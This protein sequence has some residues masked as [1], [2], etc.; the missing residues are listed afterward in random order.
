MVMAY[1][2]QN[3]VLRESCYDIWPTVLPCHP[4]RGY[5]SRQRWCYTTLGN[6][7]CQSWCCTTPVVPEQ[8]ELVFHHPGG[9]GADRVTREARVRV[10]LPWEYQSRP[11][12]YNTTLGVP[13]HPER[14][15]SPS[16]GSQSRQ[17]S[18]TPPWG[19]QSRRS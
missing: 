5:Q 12:R 14:V 4:V 2:I 19:F 15:Y 3:H 13:E 16:R 9:T 6:Q 11:S 18:I 17:P 1:P 10:T 8:T 7:S